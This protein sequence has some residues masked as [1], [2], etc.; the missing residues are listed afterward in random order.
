M[1]DEKSFQYVRSIAAFSCCTYADDTTIYEC[2]SD[3]DTIISRLET[4][5]SILAKWFSE[6]YMKHNEEKCHFMIFGNKSK[7]SVIAIGKS[8]IKESEYQKLLGL[9]FDIKLSFTKHVQYLCKKAHPKLHALA[10]LSNYI[11]PIKLRLILDA[12]LKSQFNYCPLVWMF[13]DRRANANKVKQ[14]L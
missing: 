14:S 8:I 5:S 12:F 6:N 4:D 7:D 9:T 1:S 2:N 13:H 11:D 10:R 3:L